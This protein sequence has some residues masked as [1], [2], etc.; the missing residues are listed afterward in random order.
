MNK[1]KLIAEVGVVLATPFL[2]K[3]HHK[4]VEQPKKPAIVKPWH[5]QAQQSKPADKPTNNVAGDFP[6]PQSGGLSVST[7]SGS[8]S[9][10]SSTT[11]DT[12]PTNTLTAPTTT[13][14]ASS[15]QIIQNV[16]FYG[17]PDN[18]PPGAAIAYPVIHSK[19]GG[20]GT[21][22]DPLTFATKSTFPKGTLLYVPY[23]QKYVIMEDECADCSASHIDIWMPSNG[24]FNSAVLACEDKF[25]RNNQQVILNPPNNEVVGPDLFN[26]TTGACL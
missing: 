1:F 7:G 26:V 21:F 9:T 17:W 19:A 22:T 4:P 18:D 25:T 14:S 16:T 12:T 11:N 24:Q 3:P 6:S 15:T 8:V 10:W 23:I 20:A 13:S 5:N 2:F